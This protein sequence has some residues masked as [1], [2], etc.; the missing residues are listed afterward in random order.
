MNKRIAEERKKPKPNQMDF[1]RLGGVQ[2]S[3]QSNHKKGIRR[4]SINYLSGIEKAVADIFYIVT[5]EK[6]FT[7]YLTETKHC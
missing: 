2:I 1:A 7:N 5:G 3:A 4:P 6:I